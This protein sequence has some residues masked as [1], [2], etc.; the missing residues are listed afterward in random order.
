MEQ[1]TKHDA[2]IKLE[3]AVVQ[4]LQAYGKNFDKLL[5][6]VYVALEYA[7][8]DGVIATGEKMSF[9]RRLEKSIYKD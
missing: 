4:Y 1:L 2:R 9:R 3:D 5:N 6:R 8:E 7:E